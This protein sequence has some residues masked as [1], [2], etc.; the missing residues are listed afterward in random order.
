MTM[1]ANFQSLRISD[2]SSSFFSLLVIFLT[3]FRINRSSFL[4][5]TVGMP[6]STRRDNVLAL[7]L[8]YTGT[9]H[10]S[11]R[12][13]TLASKLFDVLSLI[14]MSRSLEFCIRVLRE[15][16]FPGLSIIKIQ[17]NHSHMIL[18]TCKNIYIYRNIFQ[19]YAH[20]FSAKWATISWVFKKMALLNKVSPQISAVTYR[21]NYTIFIRA[22][23]IDS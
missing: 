12:S 19:W 11:S 14:S 9:G 2:S 22:Y 8:L 13:S 18:F 5:F 20:F 17:A 23:S 16:S 1:A 6:S 4:W 21:C 7:L 10:S 15:M 3:S